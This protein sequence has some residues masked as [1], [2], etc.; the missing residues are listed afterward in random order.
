[1]QSAASVL[2]LPDPHSSLPPA[3]LFFP[4]F[5][6]LS[7]PPLHFFRL[8]NLISGFGEVTQQLRALAALLEKLSV[9]P[10][11]GNPTPSHRHMCWKN[12]NSHKMKKDTFKGKAKG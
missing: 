12:T 10:A 9:I 6:L 11:P 1:M 8:K 7:L 5:L 3:S 2:I 4:F